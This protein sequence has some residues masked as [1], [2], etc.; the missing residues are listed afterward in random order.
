MSRSAKGHRLNNIGSTKV[1]EAT[2]QLSKASLNSFWRGRFFKGFTIY[3]HEDNL[4]HVTKPSCIMF[5]FYY[6]Q[7]LSHNILFQITRQFL[8]Q[9]IFL[10]LKSG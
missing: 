9:I 6:Y 8:R 4:A 3:G 5:L 10:S 1:L 7:K 2:Y